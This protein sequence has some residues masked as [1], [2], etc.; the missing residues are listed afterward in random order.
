[1]ANM[2]HRADVTELGCLACGLAQV[3]TRMQKQHLAKC[4]AVRPADREPVVEIEGMEDEEEDEEDEEQLAQIKGS[5]VGRLA[6]M[7]ACA[8]DKCLTVDNI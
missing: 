2:G 7:P 4:T 6:F 5:K 8:A 1:M 3:L